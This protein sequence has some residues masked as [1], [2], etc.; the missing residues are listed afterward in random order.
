VSCSYEQGNKHSNSITVG[1]LLEEFH[2]LLAF[3]D[4]VSFIK[5]ENVIL[6]TFS[7]RS[8]RKHCK[9]LVT[10]NRFQAWLGLQ[11]RLMKS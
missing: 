5:L 1:E 6:Y 4:E 2:R 9:H 8:W 3:Q 11:D 10:E 7:K